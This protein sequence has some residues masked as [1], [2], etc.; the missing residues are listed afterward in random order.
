MEYEGLAQ[1]YHKIYKES[2]IVSQELGM[3]QAKIGNLIFELASLENKIK[4]KDG[5]KTPE[6]RD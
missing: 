3:I 5:R 2:I 4:E 1:E 6:S